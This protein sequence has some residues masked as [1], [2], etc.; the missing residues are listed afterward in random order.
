MFA[1]A[2]SRAN[3]FTRIYV[4]LPDGRRQPVITMT[5]GVDWL[6][7]RALWYPNRA[8]FKQ[9]AQSLRRT[10][11][12]AVDPASTT[13]ED[14]SGT[15]SGSPGR[16]CHL[17]RADEAG[18]DGSTA[19]WKLAIEYWTIDY[20]PETRLAQASIADTMRFDWEAN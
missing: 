5:S 6:I 14:A 16:A 19:K 11:F 7:G 3:R 4:E 2:D 1:G 18:P 10:T 15:P 17:V 8:N 9:L 20:D 13:G 12:I